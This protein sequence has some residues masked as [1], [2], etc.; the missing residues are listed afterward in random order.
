M[1]ERIEALFMVSPANMEPYKESKY[2]PYADPDPIHT[3]EVSTRKQVD[4]WLK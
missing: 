1:P 3:V 2:D 4:E